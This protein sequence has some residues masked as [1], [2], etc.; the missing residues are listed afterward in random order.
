M[1]AKEIA[2]MK[3]KKNSGEY[4]EELCKRIKR[5]R[6][7]YPLTQQELSDRTGVSLRSIQNF[8]NGKDIRLDTLLKILIELDLERNIL[9]LV[10]DMEERPSMQLKKA[11]GIVRQ[12]V[13]HV[14]SGDLK[15]K[16]GDEQ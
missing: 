8:E 7:E 12:R 16:W 14:K 11:K 13:R 1:L 4:L 2:A 5:Y 9:M 6:I 15:F 10:P 3:G